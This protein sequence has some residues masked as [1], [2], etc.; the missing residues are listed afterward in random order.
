MSHPF[1]TIHGNDWIELLN[2]LKQTI[3]F[4]ARE[5]DKK[6][7]DE[8]RKFISEY[9][10]QIEENREN[11]FL[12]TAHGIV[13]YLNFY[14]VMPHEGVHDEFK[15]IYFTGMAV[16]EHLNNL[17]LTELNKLHLRAMLRL[18]DFRLAF[19]HKVNRKLLT[20]RIKSVINNNSVD[21][22][23][24]LYGWYITYKCLFN[25]ANEK[26]KTI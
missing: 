18:L 10:T 9:V 13:K 14:N 8:A 5:E 11:I 17:E 23:L 7:E 26:S 16:S 15:G 22:H 1:V 6:T 12:V 25:A 21:K 19:P 24:G 4:L 20:T 3:Y 2:Y